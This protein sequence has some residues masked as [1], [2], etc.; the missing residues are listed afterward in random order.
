MPRGVGE[1]AWTAARSVAGG[2][3]RSIGTALNEKRI[4]LAVTGLSRAGKTV[5]ITSVIQNLIALGDGW[6]TLPRIAA[7]LQ[8]QGGHTRLRRVTLLPTGVETVPYFDF[9]TNLAGLA[10]EKPKWPD[11]TQHI[12]QISLSLEIEYESTFRQRL[13]YKRVRLDI[14]DYPGEWLLDLPMLD[15]VV[16]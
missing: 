11:Q 15:R 5:F 14:L 12:A 8:H 9:R 16:C 10:A 13:G 6:N 4:R 3:S 7:R 1:R 2:A